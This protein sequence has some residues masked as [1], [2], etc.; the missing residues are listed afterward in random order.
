MRRG[1][2]RRE[3][4]NLKQEM[5]ML[6]WSQFYLIFSFTIHWNRSLFYFNVSIFL[7]IGHNNE[8]KYK[9]KFLHFCVR[10][11][12]CKVFW[13]NVV[14]IIRSMCLYSYQLRKPDKIEFL[15]IHYSEFNYISTKSALIWLTRILTSNLKL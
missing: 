10:L 3:K 12:N 5:A 2:G 8:K 1:W 15:R 11:K 6:R 7:K 14:K 4:A 9:K 13:L